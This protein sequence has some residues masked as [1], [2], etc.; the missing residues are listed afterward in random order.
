ME[1]L[2]ILY[3]ATIRYTFMEYI[4]IND[5][6]IL[7]SGVDWIGSFTLKNCYPV[8]VVYITNHNINE[9]STTYYYDIVEGIPNPDVFIP[10]KECETAEWADPPE[11]CPWMFHDEF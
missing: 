8:R 5:M 2:I 6:I 10:P 9:T 3:I 7:F 11:D 4:N 1:S